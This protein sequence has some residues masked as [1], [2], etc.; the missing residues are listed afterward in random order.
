MINKEDYILV[1]QNEFNIN[2]YYEFVDEEDVLLEIFKY[3][4]KVSGTND[5][6]IISLLSNKVDI[7][8]QQINNNGKFV[9]L[10]NGNSY[11]FTYY[12]INKTFCLN[13]SGHNVFKDYKHYNIVIIYLNKK[14]KIKNEI[15]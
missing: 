6:K 10:H 3:N 9:L 8:L 11:E 4:Y 14:N 7:I 2:D 5:N 12:F 15:K 1:D 13:K